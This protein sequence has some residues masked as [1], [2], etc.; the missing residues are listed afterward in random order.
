MSYIKKYLFFIPLCVCCYIGYTQNSDTIFWNK[1]YRL[2]FD[3]FKSTPDFD[4][5]IAKAISYLGFTLPSYVKNDTIYINLNSYFVKK[6]LGLLKKKKLQMKIKIY[7]LTN[8]G[9]LI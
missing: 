6:N 9:T 3:D 8:R 5:E 4:N 2:K 7:L 1:S